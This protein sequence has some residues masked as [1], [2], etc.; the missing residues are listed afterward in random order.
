M[1]KRALIV[2][3]EAA[4]CELIEKVLG[5]VGIESLVLNKSTEAAC[6][7]RE[8]KF[9]IIFLDFGTALPDGA[10]LTRQARESGFN[11]MTPIVL[12]SDDQRPH[13]MSQ[14]FEAGASFFLY[15]P[16]DKERLLK[17]VRATQGT[18]EHERRR[19]RRVPL[20][21]RV[22]L[23][24]GGQQIEGETVDVSM[25]GVLVKAP[26]SLPIGSSVDVSLHLSKEMK[27]VEGAGCVVRL[28]GANQMGIHLGRLVPAES[29]RLQ[30]FLLSMVPAV[31]Q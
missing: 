5:S 23:R 20:I 14:G 30:E 7:L 13:A 19:T 21:S 4:T 1:Q 6:V 3:D 24:I 17:L 29:Q 22:Q 18:I 8:G 26:R 28:P 16:I 12:L 27:P 11:R 31:V 9:A 10:E 25:E 15:K 2:D